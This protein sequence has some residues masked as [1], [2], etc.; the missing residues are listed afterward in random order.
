MY[1]MYVL[2]KYSTYYWHILYPCVY[3]YG[4]LDYCGSSQHGI[5]DATTGFC[6]STIKVLSAIKDEGD[7]VP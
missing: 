3:K 5:S 1:Y 2:Y 7:I 6:V 4:R